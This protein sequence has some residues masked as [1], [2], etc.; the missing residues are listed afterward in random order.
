M[1]TARNGHRTAPSDYRTLMSSFPTG[2]AVVCALDSGGRPHGMTCTS[3]CSV[4][5]DPPTLLVS[6]HVHSGTYQAVRDSNCF[7][8]NLLHARGRRAAELFA[9]AAPDR[10]RRV[11][12][13]RS[14]VV[15][16][17]RL[18]DD[19]FALAECRVSEVFPAGDHMLVLGEVV[20]TV[21]GGAEPLLYGLR[22][23]TVWPDPVP[24]ARPAEAAGP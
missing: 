19:A 21:H 17:P 3:L 4:T 10:F 14:E 13:R 20:G 5:A 16:A 24:R 11:V 2:V 15:G 7:T 12:W 8:L 6:L 22:Q 23:F 18:V 9:S 1:G